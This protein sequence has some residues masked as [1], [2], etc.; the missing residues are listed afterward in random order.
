MINVKEATERFDALSNR[1]RWEAKNFQSRKGDGAMKLKRL[2]QILAF[3]D[4]FLA[5]L[6]NY[7]S[8]IDAY[9][10]SSGPKASFDPLNFESFKKIC[11]ILAEFEA[12]LKEYEQ[13]HP[14]ISPPR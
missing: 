4:K 12:E 8:D 5:A 13:L 9:G 6:K 11:F 14:L 10:K 1:F 3:Y 7:Y 2:E